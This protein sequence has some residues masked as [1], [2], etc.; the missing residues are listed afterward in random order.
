MLVCQASGWLSE[1]SFPEYL[2]KAEAALT[3]EEA[4]LNFGMG[5]MYTRWLDQYQ[6]DQTKEGAS[7]NFVPALGSGAGAHES[8]VKCRIPFKGGPRGALRPRVHQDPGVRT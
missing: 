4:S 1:D 8:A 5:A 6:D 3:A 7:N 2:R